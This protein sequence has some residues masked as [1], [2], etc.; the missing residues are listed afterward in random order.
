MLNL[1]PIKKHRLVI[2]KNKYIKRIINVEAVA[3][4]LTQNNN[5]NLFRSLVGKS[6]AMQNIQHEIKQVATSDANVL[7]LG[8]SGTGKEVVARNVHYFS[9]RKGKNFVPVNCGAIPP[10]LL[11]SELFGH[12]KGAFTG[13]ITSR[14]GRFSMAE[15]GTLFLDEIGEMTKS[16]QVKCLS[17]WEII[18]IE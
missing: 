14:Q 17:H 6:Q 1:I 3:K 5:N 8:E 18:R 10:D 9:N 13:A 2:F 11:E 12:E 15:G 4:K 7:I 16:M